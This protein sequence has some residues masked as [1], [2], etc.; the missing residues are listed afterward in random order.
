[1]FCLLALSDTRRRALDFCKDV[2]NDPNVASFVNEKFVAWGGDV[3]NSDA[4][5]LALGVSPSSFPY[6]ALLNSSGFA[7]FARRLC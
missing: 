2:L 3:S 4:L 5:L 1:M 6:C 7:R